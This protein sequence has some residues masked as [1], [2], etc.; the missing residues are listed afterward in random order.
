MPQSFGGTVTMDTCRPWKHADHG[1]MQTMD[2]CRPWIQ[3]DMIGG[4]QSLGHQMSVVSTMHLVAQVL[5][6]FHSWYTAICPCW[7]GSQRPA[8][9]QFLAFPRMHGNA[10]RMHASRT[11]RKPCQT[12]LYM[13]GGVCYNMHDEIPHDPNE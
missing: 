7:D 6:P 1:N 2:I 13:L 9:P 11:Q 12:W 4:H 8:P 5:R 3:A 10:S